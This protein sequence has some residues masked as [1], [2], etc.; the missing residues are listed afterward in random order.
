MKNRRRSLFIFLC[1]AP[2]AVLLFIFMIV[3]TFNVFRMSLYKW[4]GYSAEKT[5]V[6]FNNFKTLASD[7]K[8]LRA[9]QNSILIITVVTLVTLALAIIF[10]YIL[11]RE[12]I[13]GQALFRTIFYI[14]N[15]LSIVVVAAIFSAVYDQRDGLLNSI[16]YIFRPVAPDGK[17]LIAWLGNQRLV[18]WAIIIALIWQAIGYY[19]VMYMASMAG[20]PESIYESAS[21]E[22]AGKVRQFF[23]MTLPMI[24]INIRSTLTFFIISTIN[25]SFQLVKAMTGGKPDG[26][27]D[28]FLNYM[29]DQAYT[30]SS[31]GYGMA[32]G[33]VIFLFSFALAAV[34]NRVTK[35]DALEF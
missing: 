13:K 14:P 29:Y 31:Y 20:V 12:K 10:A 25:L 35:R 24:W 33:V 4:G 28:V 27:S 22:G 9:M 8:F 18:V 26:A 30:N 5:F 1:V 3:P 32:I 6:G 34:V 19:M 2:A 15:I 17:G 16:I 21:L 11:S 7:M 23:S